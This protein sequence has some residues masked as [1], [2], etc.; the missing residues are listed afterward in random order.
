MTADTLI[1]ASMPTQNGIISAVEISSEASEKVP[2]RLEPLEV[3]WQFVH[4]YYT[5]LNKD[6]NRLHCFY[7][8]TSTMVHGVEGENAKTCS[9]QQEIHLRFKELS[10]LNSKV[11]VSNVDSLRSLA[12]GIV[13]SVL[14]EMETSGQPAR[15]FSQC[16]VLAEQPNG[17]FVLNDIF[18]YLK[19]APIASSAIASHAVSSIVEEQHIEP[20]PQQE[21]EAVEVEVVNVVEAEQKAEPAVDSCVENVMIP[22]PATVEAPVEPAVVVVAPRPASPAAAPV[23]ETPR[24]PVAAPVEDVT[25]AK[26]ANSGKE[27]WAGHATSEIKGKTVSANPLPKVSTRPAAQQSTGHSPKS[28]EQN[29]EFLAS[30][31][32]ITKA[33][34]VPQL[35]EEF[36]K[37]GISVMWVDLVSEHNCTIQLSDKE[38][39]KK[40]I[41]MK[42]LAVNGETAVISEKTGGTFNRRNFYKNQ[43][44]GASKSP[45]S[46]SDQHRQSSHK[47]KPSPHPPKK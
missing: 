33:T 47:F 32:G 1:T 2:R 8:K 31:T 39:W 4:E 10:L 29:P 38:T 43:A 26:L 40:A 37:A 44:S 45:S 5:I 3:G 24:Q 9:G 12:F 46:G 30:V 17:Y 34:R 7:N 6:P 36:A 28:A 21:Q 18:R 23:V 13:V 35:K 11:I 41:A 27:R 42:T 15:S 19:A 22:V 25:W 20:V 16:F 14:G